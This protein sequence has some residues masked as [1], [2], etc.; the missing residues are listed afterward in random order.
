MPPPRQG[1]YYHTDVYTRQAKYLTYIPDIG[2]L[3]HP[4]PGGTIPIMEHETP[5]SKAKKRDPFPPEIADFGHTLRLLRVRHNLSQEKLADAVGMNRSYLSDVE[6]G[7]NSISLQYMVKVAKVLKIK[8][9]ALFLLME[10]HADEETRRDLL[11]AER[12]RQVDERSAEMVGRT[13]GRL[14]R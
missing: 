13:R 5:A 6:R 12:L 4:V 3:T 14:D 1:I 7:L 8:L 11:L 2:V 9:S 10:E